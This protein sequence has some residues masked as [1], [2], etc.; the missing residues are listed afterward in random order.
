M[1][2]SKCGTDFQGNFCHN[3]GS[4][5]PGVAQTNNKTPQII[6]VSIAVVCFCFV[7]IIVGS[8]LFPSKVDP[9][10]QRKHDIAKASILAV[11]EY[12]S[13]IECPQP[14]F[15]TISENPDR[16]ITASVRDTSANIYVMLTDSA[17]GI[18]PYFIKC[19]K[20]V[21]LNNTPSDHIVIESSSPESAASKKQNDICRK[22][23]DAAEA[24]IQGAKANALISGKNLKVSI[25]VSGLTSSADKATI[26]EL[27]PTAETASKDIAAIVKEADLQASAMTIVGDDDKSSILLTYVNGTMTFNSSAET[28]SS[29]NDPTITLEEFEKI[30]TGMSL[31]EVVDIVG[32]VGEKLSSVD[33]G[34]GLEYISE[35]FSWTGDG[36]IGANA[37]VTF[38]GGK[39]CA[40]A[41]IGLK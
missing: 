37:N 23:E 27:I 36:S 9:E 25:T 5:V 4:P 35:M 3:C 39:V 14:R 33:L 8:I 31:Q 12:V 15:W 2:C 30:Q 20:T 10:E 16:T 22:A 38:Q 40:K 29:S 18:E 41:Q 1:K 19:G 24:S 26:D 21:Y 11:E 32:G 6:I 7:G 17:N 13:D 28:E 34:M